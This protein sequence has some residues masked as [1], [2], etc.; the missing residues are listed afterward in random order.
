MTSLPAVEWA[1]RDTG[2]CAAPAGARPKLTA[3]IATAPAPHRAALHEPDG[4]PASVR[5]DARP[6]IE[7][8]DGRICR[9]TADRPPARAS[10]NCIC[11]D[12]PA[13]EWRSPVGI[14]ENARKNG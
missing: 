11:V 10:L 6:V 5:R 8:E 7:A 4:A 2:L 13:R 9:W 12:A 3:A 14:A 1:W